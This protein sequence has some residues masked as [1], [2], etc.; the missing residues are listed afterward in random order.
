MPVIRGEEVETIEDI[1]INLFYK[2]HGQSVTVKVRRP[3]FL[4]PDAVMDF[5][6]QL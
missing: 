2:E 6:V 5:D 4:F 1:K 3:I